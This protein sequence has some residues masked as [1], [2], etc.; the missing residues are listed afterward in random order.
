MEDD[1]GWLQHLVDD[2]CL[3]IKSQKKIFFEPLYPFL[4]NPIT[5]TTLQAQ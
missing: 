2:P 5:L 3:K 1:L 4:H